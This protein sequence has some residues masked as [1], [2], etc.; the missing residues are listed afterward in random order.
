M[1]SAYRKAEQRL[2]RGRGGPLGWEIRQS[3]LTQWYV[4]TLWDHLQVEPATNKQKQTNKVD[5]GK[6]EQLL[7]R[8]WSG[9]GSSN[10]MKQTAGATELQDSE[11]VNAASRDQLKPEA[12]EH[13][14]CQYREFEYY[15][16]IKVIWAL[17]SK[18]YILTDVQKIYNHACVLLWLQCGERWAGWSGRRTVVPVAPAREGAG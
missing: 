15:A 2:Q 12:L 8:T 11:W 10:L 3:L 1:L 7:E 18:W 6:T 5:S 13:L 17:S 16:Y 4:L 9:V 14:V